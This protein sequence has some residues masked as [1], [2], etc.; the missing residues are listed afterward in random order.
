MCVALR[1]TSS[2]ACCV[3][4][5]WVIF[6]TRGALALTDSNVV[7]IVIRRNAESIYVFRRHARYTDSSAA[8]GGN[9]AV[10]IV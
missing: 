6:E 3:S 8:A 9:A 7:R 10:H 1:R 5:K 2:D 4:C